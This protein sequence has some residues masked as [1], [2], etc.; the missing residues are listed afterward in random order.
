MI[1]YFVFF[2]TVVKTFTKKNKKR[3]RFSSKAST[4]KV[5]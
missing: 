3:L 1:L 5:Y 4:M 2:F